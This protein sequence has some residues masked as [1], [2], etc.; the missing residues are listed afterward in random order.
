M[1][2]ATILSAQK[3][4]TKRPRIRRR[5]TSSDQVSELTTNRLS[6]YLRAWNALEDAGVR[7][8]LL[9]GASPSSF[10]S[11]R[12]RSGK[13]WPTSV[14]SACVASATTSRDPTAPSPD[15]RVRPKV[16]RRSSAPG[17]WSRACS[18]TRASSARASRSSPSSSTPRL[19][20]RRPFSR[21][22]VPI[23]DPSLR[24]DENRAVP[25]GIR[26]SPSLPCPPF[27]SARREPRGRG[28]HQGHSEFLARH[29]SRTGRREA[30]ERGP[31]GI[32]REP[33][34]L[35]GAGNR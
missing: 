31:H 21:R 13:T 27:R 33:V 3:T 4:R 2:F 20:G 35:L 34:V 1:A 25:R 32:A 17:T 16:A 26:A 12:P 6:V 23:N 18:T 15:S 8:H 30:Q 14:S 11:M 10:N 29:A 19:E 22:G 28:R 7:D 24:S 5:K 9:S